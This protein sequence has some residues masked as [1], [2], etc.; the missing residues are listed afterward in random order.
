VG[1][2]SP[3][4]PSS[5][6]ARVK[7]YLANVREGPGAE[8]AVLTTVRKGETLQVQARTPDGWLKVTTPDGQTGW[9]YSDLLSF[10]PEPGVAASSGVQASSADSHA[11]PAAG[12][13]VGMAAGLPGGQILDPKS[14]Q[15]YWIL[16]EAIEA[17]APGSTLVL[18]PGRFPGRIVIHKTLYLYGA[19]MDQTILELSRS[20][21][22]SFWIAEDCPDGLLSNMELA[23]GRRDLPVLEI[24]GKW[25]GVVESCRIRGGGGPGVLITDTVTASLRRCELVEN[26]DV[27]IEIRDKAQPRIEF[28]S[29]QKGHGGG[30]AILDESKPLLAGNRILETGSFGVQIGDRAQPTL[31]NN[32]VRGCR[33]D[34]VYVSG[35]AAPTLQQNQLVGNAIK[36]SDTANLTF[37]EDAAGTILENV[38]EGA[39]RRPGVLFTKN[40]HPLLGSNQIRHNRIG[41]QFEGQSFP[42]LKDNQ[43][44]SNGK[45]TEDKRRGKKG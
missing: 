38:I 40:A 1:T 39:E 41:M 26:G 15:R 34:G 7:V 19:G 44:E 42:T 16:Q 4:G 3:S 36:R 20:S 18:G 10:G 8:H 24:S 11:E 31:Q 12:D 2:P 37:D 9:V 30:I 43:L 22:D 14:G 5:G 17:A 6:P 45:D 32:E 35:Q 29:I 23:G 27:A 25:P 13:F 33:N 21:K 28:C